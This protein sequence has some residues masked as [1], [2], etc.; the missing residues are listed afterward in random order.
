MGPFSGHK[1]SGL[2]CC[3]RPQNSRVPPQNLRNGSLFGPFLGPFLRPENG[4][5]FGATLELFSEPWA[6]KTITC[7]GTPLFTKNTP[8]RRIVPLSHIHSHDTSLSIED[9]RYLPQA[10]I[11]HASGYHLWKKWYTTSLANIPYDTNILHNRNKCN[12]LHLVA[13]K[14]K[15]DLNSHRSEVLLHIRILFLVGSCL[16][17]GIAVQVFLVLTA[18]LWHVVCCTNHW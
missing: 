16:H 18:H 8:F 13:G 12:G 3:P 2:G 10:T 14:R 4:R 15:V 11:Y 6:L 1:N 5:V 7:Q 17:G 9:W